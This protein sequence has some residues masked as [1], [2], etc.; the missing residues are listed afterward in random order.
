MHYTIRHTHAEGTTI[1]VPAKR[2]PIGHA[3][4]RA[5]WRYSS[6]LSRWY[7]PET[8]GKPAKERAIQFTITALERS[9]AQIS[10]DIEHPGPPAQAK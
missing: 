7:L 2:S 10:V 8:T 5:G 6:H 3:L 1:D 4:S 9:G